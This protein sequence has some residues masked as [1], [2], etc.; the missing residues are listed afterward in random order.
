M[1]TIQFSRDFDYLA[2][3][4]HIISY[5]AGSLVERVPEAAVAKILEAGVGEVVAGGDVPED[6]PA[7][8]EKPAK[9]LRGK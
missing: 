3:K 5:K 6:E 1:K 8:E 4:H 9:K 2:T 7:A